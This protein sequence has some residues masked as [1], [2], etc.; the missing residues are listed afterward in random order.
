MRWW[1]RVDGA[2]TALIESSTGTRHSYAARVMHD[3][4]RLSAIGSAMSLIAASLAERDAQLESFGGGDEVVGRQPLAGFRI[5][6]VAAVAIDAPERLLHRHLAAQARQPVVGR[7][8]AKPRRPDHLA[9]HPG[10]A[11]HAGDPG[12]LGR[13]GQ[14]QLRYPGSN[15]ARC[16]QA[17]QDGPVN[18]GPERRADRATHRPAQ[19]GSDRGQDHLGHD[20]ISCGKAKAATSRSRHQRPSQ[21][22]TQARPQ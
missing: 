19:G 22:S 8:L 16:R 6:I 3:P 1:A 2:R 7:P 11:E 9:T 15:R 21:L 10:P 12:S 18:R 20:V 5:H 4:L 13:P 17:V 14:T